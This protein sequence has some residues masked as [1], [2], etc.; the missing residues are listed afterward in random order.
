[1]D[2]RDQICMHDHGAFH[3]DHHG[4]GRSCASNVIAVTSQKAQNWQDGGFLLGV[5]L[6]SCWLALRTVWSVKSKV[7]CGMTSTRWDIRT[8]WSGKQAD[9][10]RTQNFVQKY[11]D[12]ATTITSN[13]SCSITEPMALLVHYLSTPWWSSLTNT[14]KVT[15]VASMQLLCCCLCF[16]FSIVYLLNRR[17]SF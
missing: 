16:L 13:V 12:H 2:P 17:Y 9:K 1:M 10:S 7:S 8:Q 14:Y 5:P 3:E 4:V 15:R 6:S 11:L